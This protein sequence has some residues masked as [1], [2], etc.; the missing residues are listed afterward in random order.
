M[1]DQ[2]IPKDKKKFFQAL[3]IPRVEQ[4]ERDSSRK[5]VPEKNFSNNSGK[6]LEVA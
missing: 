3:V 2:L 1:T 5:K 4:N 6:K